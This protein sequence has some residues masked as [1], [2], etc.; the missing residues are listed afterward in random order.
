MMER[1]QRDLDSQA[2]AHC[3]AGVRGRPESPDQNPKQKACEEI[4]KHGGSFS[5]VTWSPK[6]TRLGTKS[7]WVMNPFLSAMQN[8]WGVRWPLASLAPGT[9]E[10]N[11]LSD[12]KLQSQANGPNGGFAM[13]RRLA[14]SY[15]AP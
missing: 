8:C 7:P 9:S 13:G 10:L 6:R 3:E 4:L 12:L 2:A 1:K 11:E 5:K 15:F 14:T